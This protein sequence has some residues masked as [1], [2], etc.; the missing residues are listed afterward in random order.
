MIPLVVIP[1]FVG[2]MKKARFFHEMPLS[3][4]FLPILLLPVFWQ[5]M[6]YWGKPEFNRTGIGQYTLVDFPFGWKNI[7]TNVDDNLFVLM[8]LNPNYGFSPIL[9]GLSLLG[10]YLFLRRIIKRKQPKRA[11]RLFFMASGVFLLLFVFISSFYWVNFG[12]PMDMRLSLIFLPFLCWS[13]VYGVFHV[14]KHIFQKYQKSFNT[15]L[16]LFSVAHLLFF[17]PT[18]AHQRLLKEMLLPY[19]YSR[20]LDFLKTDCPDSNHTLIISEFPNLYLV[21]EYSALKIN[22]LQKV[23]SVAKH[24]NNFER[25]LLFQRYNKQSGLILSQHRVAVPDC[26]LREIKELSLSPKLGLR[27]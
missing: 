20:V 24:S 26:A 2:K 9:F 12:I 1:F 6:I 5:R 21:Q 19:E 4:A 8:R 15:W 25:I 3:T 13:A 10:T 27:V 16:V 14:Q 11:K 22:N 7:I 17:W 23:L 18:G